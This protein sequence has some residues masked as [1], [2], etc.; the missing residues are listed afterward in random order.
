[1]VDT[2]KGATKVDG[3]DRRHMSSINAS[4]DPFDSV[5]QGVL[6]RM[7]FPVRVLGLSENM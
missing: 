7:T 3:G 1:M 2:V 6:R 4:H 5:D